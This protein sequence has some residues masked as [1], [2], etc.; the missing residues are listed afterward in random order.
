MKLDH[1]AYRVD[2]RKAAADFMVKQLGYLIV[3]N[4]HLDFDDGT[5]ADCYALSKD[6][7]TDIFISQGQAGSV[8]AQWVEDNGGV[9]GI[10][11]IAYRV[12]SVATTMKNWM[13][14][15]VAEF[16]T[17]Q[18]IVGVNLVQAFTKPHPLTGVTYEL[19]ERDEGVIGFE[20]ENVKR[21]MESTK[22]L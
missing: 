8:A 5:V 2:D 17:P 9:G 6:G 18:P 11:H 14:N 16:T 21:L 13:E 10:H 4:F 19:I 3:D 7:E 15:N 12:P 22:N 1:L 20:P